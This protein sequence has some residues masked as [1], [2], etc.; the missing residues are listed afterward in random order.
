M[1]LD[2]KKKFKNLYLPEKNPS[3]IDVPS[4][5]F[6]VI[7][8]EGNPNSNEFSLKVEALYGFSYAV[9]MSY[10]SKS[11]PEGFYDYVVFPLEGVWDLL[12]KSKSN[13]SKDNY[14]YSIMI[15]QPEF[16]TDELFPRFVDEVKN[17]KSIATTRTF[18]HPIILI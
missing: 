7:K 8:G 17:K 10:K 18:D 16:L 4:I 1:K 3:I 12:D 2:Y 9:K 11:V 14:K 6:A 13:K 15:R 5:K